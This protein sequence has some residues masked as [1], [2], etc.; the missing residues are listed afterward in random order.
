[1]RGQFLGILMKIIIS[2]IKWPCDM[3]MLPEKAKRPRIEALAMTI[4]V[5]D[6]SVSEKQ[7]YTAML[8]GVKGQSVKKQKIFGYNMV[9]STSV[10][11]HL[12]LELPKASQLA[13]ACDTY[14]LHPSGDQQGSPGSTQ[15]AFVLHAFYLGAGQAF[16]GQGAFN[17]VG[18]VPSGFG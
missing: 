2:L 3:L 13:I 15:D 6:E 5:V 18:G 1:M 10:E 11:V 8:F 7:I 14:S 16:C 17:A 12:K 9:L 4:R